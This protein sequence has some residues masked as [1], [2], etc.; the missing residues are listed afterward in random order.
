MLGTSLPAFNYKVFS[1]NHFPAAP[2]HGGESKFKIVQVSSVDRHFGS[3]FV[4]HGDGQEEMS[5]KFA[6]LW[7]DFSHL[8]TGFLG[9]LDEPVSWNTAATNDMV[10]REQCSV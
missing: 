2:I 3:S 8:Y 9:L 7:V 4:Y 10:A 1:L 5:G 6:A